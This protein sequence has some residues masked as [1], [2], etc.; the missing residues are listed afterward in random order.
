M[1]AYAVR[2]LTQKILLSEN[3]RERAKASS[4]ILQRQAQSLPST[5]LG[6]R[7]TAVT[8]TPLQ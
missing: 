4:N 2:F 7:K 1:L 6:T 8:K 5:M 3:M